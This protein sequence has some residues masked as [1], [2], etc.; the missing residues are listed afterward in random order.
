[1]ALLN[2]LSILFMMSAGDLHSGENCLVIDTF[3]SCMTSRGL[4]C[5]W[6]PSRSDVSMFSIQ[7]EGEGHYLRIE[8]RGGCTS[9]ARKME[10]SP[11][12][13]PR[14]SWRWRVHRLP[15]R[16][17]EDVRARDDSGAGVYVVFAAR[18][19]LN[20]MIKYVWSTTLEVGATTESPYNG[21]VKI[22]VRRSGTG[23]LGRWVREE[24]NVLEDYT[25]L[26]GSAP[27][28]NAIAI[29]V[30]SD[31]DNTNSNVKADYDSFCLRP[32]P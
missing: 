24:V 11:V 19:L 3:S 12:E 5:G 32:G 8:T 22:V 10:F 13:Y 4:P 29:A 15:E 27:S 30:L 16:G 14:L 2:A 17:R 23:M 25:K 1:M 7:R 9:I 26:F 20:R 31:S 6:H 28:K 18:F 21:R